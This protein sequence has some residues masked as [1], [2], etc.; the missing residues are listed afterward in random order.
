MAYTPTNW[1]PND[2]VTTERMNKLERGVAAA[3][4][5]IVYANL[6][7]RLDKTW[8]EIRNALSAIIVFD[9]G[10][11]VYIGHVGEL[12]YSVNRYS[13]TTTSGAV[14]VATSA[15]GYPEAE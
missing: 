12:Q 11:H 8:Q 14:Y 5:L 1:R 3:G 6:N 13:V 2:V 15:D 4:P 9:N 10:A 7:G